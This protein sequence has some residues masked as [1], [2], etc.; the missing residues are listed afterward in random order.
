[1]S[2]WIQILCILSLISCESLDAQKPF[3]TPKMVEDQAAAGKRVK[4][5]ADGY[6]HTNV[7]HSLY[8]PEGYS[9]EKKYPIIVEYTGN[10]APHLGSSGQVKDASLA[11]ATAVALD[12]I[13]VVM[14]YLSADGM[15][16]ELT[17]WGSETKTIDYC[18][19]QVKE[20]CLNYGGDPSSVF[21]TGFSRGAIAVNRLGLNDD[22]AAD[23]WLGF[24]SHDHYDG[25]RAWCTDWAHNCDYNAYRASAIERAKRFRGRAALV[26]GQH[27]DSVAGYI[28]TSGIDTLGKLS[29]QSVPVPEIIPQDELFTNPKNRQKVTHTDKWMNYESEEADDVVDWYKEVIRD[30]PGTYS[31]SGIVRDTQGKPVPGVIVESG[32]QGVDYKGVCTHF[33]ISSCDGEYELKGL[34][35]GDRFVNVTYLQAPG[36][37]LN[38]QNIILDKNKLLDIEIDQGKRIHYNTAS[39]EEIGKRMAESYLE[40]SIA[41]K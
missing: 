38:T 4:I 20:I 11:Y 31:I 33:D 10:F 7:Y 23:I 34:I 39:Q 27:M 1:M 24:H 9:R 35:Q 13:W 5:V 40:L 18:A 8:L 29:I 21:I 32:L 37:I 41:R 26:G 12:A 6:E 17:W 36:I 30:K 19:R 28:S 25:H 16:S 3:K 22:R 2:T 15:N 14:P